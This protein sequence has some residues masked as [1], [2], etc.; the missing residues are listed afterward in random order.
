MRLSAPSSRIPSSLFAFLLQGDLE[1]AREAFGAFLRDYAWARQ[2]ADV[3]EGFL[4]AGPI[5]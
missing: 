1:A 2:V 3:P 5:R 4:P